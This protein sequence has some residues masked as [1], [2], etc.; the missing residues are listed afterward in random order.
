MFARG[1]NSIRGL[2]VSFKVA[3]FNGSKTLDKEEFED[4]MGYCGLFLTMPQVSAV[5]K[6]FDKDGSGTIVYDEFLRGLAGS[7]PER[8]QHM[9][10]K[11]FRLMDKDGSGELTTDDL[12]GIFNCKK[13]PKVLEG[14]MSEEDAL[15]DFLKSF[16]GS[17]KKDGI[18][19]KDE[20]VEYYT[21]LSASIPSD[22]YFVVMMESVWMVNEKAGSPET[23]AKVERWVGELK[24]KISQ[25]GKATETDAEKLRKLFKYFD[26]DET[27]TV[28]ID[29]F[30]AA[31]GRL[32][33][34]LER[35]DTRAFFN[36]Y[37]KDLSGFLSY[38]EFIRNVV[39]V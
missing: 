17:T 32:G 25:K 23:M 29:E 4:A 11:A 37:D 39:G 19:T 28:T 18:I 12:V 16:E 3:D 14:S 7:L 34:S 27:G 30:S 36:V 8:R 20:W 38:E 2:A 31:M 10:D 35:R 6:Y 15:T 21:Q 24:A 26:T 9:V 22:D 33:I 13:H 5:F 1:G